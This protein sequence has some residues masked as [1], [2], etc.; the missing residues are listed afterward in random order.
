MRRDTRSR[1][2]LRVREP[3]PQKIAGRGRFPGRR[4]RV[5]VS[6]CRPRC[7][8]RSTA[9]RPP[10]P[11]NRRRSAAGTGSPQQ[12]CPPVRES[13]PKG[14]L[15]DRLPKQ[16]PAPGPRLPSAPRGRPRRSCPARRSPQREFRRRQRQRRG[17]A[18]RRLRT[19]REKSGGNDPRH[20]PTSTALNW[21]SQP[22]AAQI[23]H[24]RANSR[25]HRRIVSSSTT[26]SGRRP[27]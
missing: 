3:V 9:H 17:R 1:P 7:R 23:A 6:E 13:L 5:E 12:R 26:A 27:R 14:R 15:R 20:A 19:R 8:A 25:S 2:S 10:P 16:A 4:S 21:Q 24:D 11:E 22:S 18:S